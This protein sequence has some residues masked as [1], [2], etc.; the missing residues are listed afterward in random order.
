MEVVTYLKI[1]GRYWWVVLLTALISTGVAAAI[2]FTKSPTYSVQARVVARP[3]TGVLTDTRDLV[4]MISQLG[5]K[6]VIGTFAQLFTSA[7]VQKQAQDEVGLNPTTAKD[8]PI[9]AN[10]LPDTTVIELTA[11]GRDPQLLTNYVNATVN[12]SVASGLELYRVIELA[13]IE[14]AVVPTAPTSPVPSR[15]IPIGA[16]LGLALGILL[17][18]AIEYLRMPRRVA[19]E[20]QIRSLVPNG[21]QALPSAMPSLAPPPPNA[22][23]IG[24]DDMTVINGGRLTTGYLLPGR[25]PRVGSW[26]NDADAEPQHGDALQPTR[27]DN[28]YPG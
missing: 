22:Q 20:P 9:E 16:G 17:A 23:Q 26:P 25:Q 15:D 13:P 14:M 28:S 24:H 3:A 27:K 5:M 7:D 4:N 1:I 12:A 11:K 8:Y 6:S 19:Y 2:S 21:V 10:V 18:L